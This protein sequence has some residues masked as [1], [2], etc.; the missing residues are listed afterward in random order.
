MAHRDR[1]DPEGAELHRVPD[2]HLSQVRLAQDSVLP[3][4]GLQQA[5]GETSPEHRRV[6]LL[7]GEREAADVV[8]M[9]M[10]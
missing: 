7:Q 4:L 10:R 3:Q 5:K 1:L 8:L 2:P 6:E 9:P